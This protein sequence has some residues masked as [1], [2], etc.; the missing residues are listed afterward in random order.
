MAKD[1]PACISPHRAE[2]EARLKG[3]E[4]VR[5][6]SRWLLSEK[7]ELIPKSTLHKHAHEHLALPSLF[8]AKLLSLPRLVAALTPSP[9][10]ESLPSD[11]ALPPLEALAHIQNKAIAVFDALTDDMGEAGLSPQQVSLFTG[12]LKEARQAAKNRHELVHGKKYVVNAQVVTRP[13]L[14]D[15]STEDL[16]KK[17]DEIK[18]GLT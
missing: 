9:Q 10:T 2:I 1:C 14:K 12:T 3:K 7:S 8:A 4:S 13:E 5:S 6:V 16:A 15:A 17:R 11:T 18:R